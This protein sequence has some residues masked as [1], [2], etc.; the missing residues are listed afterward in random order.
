MQEVVHLLTNFPHVQDPDD[1]SIYYHPVYFTFENEKQ[2]PCV[3]RAL[4]DYNQ[5]RADELTFCKDAIITNVEKHEGGW[6]RGDYGRRKKKWFPA[7]YVEEV[8]TNDP[9]S[10]EK[11]LGNLQQGAIDV[12]GQF[13]TPKCGHFGDLERAS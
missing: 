5:R 11:Q 3:V 13:Q 4:Y 7:N 12:A 1:N 9:S 2:L 6:W 10:E 8:D